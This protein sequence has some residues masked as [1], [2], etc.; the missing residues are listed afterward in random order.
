MCY[1]K[2]FNEKKRE[3]LIKICKK[4]KKHCEQF[5]TF[6]I[7]DKKTNKKSKSMQ[8]VF[9]FIGVNIPDNSQNTT[10]FAQKA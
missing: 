4:Q 2:R 3:Q 5:S 1:A 9:M 6:S 8:L 10:I 7:K